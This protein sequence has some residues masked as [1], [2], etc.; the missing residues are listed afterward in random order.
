[1][2]Q[3]I[4]WPD[5]ILLYAA[6]VAVY[7][8]LFTLNLMQKIVSLMAWFLN[9][10]ENGI[11][12]LFAALQ[13]KSEERERYLTQ[14][15]GGYEVDFYFFLTLTVGCSV[16]F[17]VVEKNDKDDKKKETISESSAWSWMEAQLQVIVQTYFFYFHSIRFIHLIAR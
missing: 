1:M 6:W 3:I 5:P 4:R 10:H 11:Q 15:F 17:H 16:T 7:P 2:L 9:S 14:W 13:R 8:T 12:M